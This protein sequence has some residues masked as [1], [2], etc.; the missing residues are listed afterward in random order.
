MTGSKEMFMEQREMEMNEI[1]FSKLP[2]TKANITAQAETAVAHII[3]GQDAFSIAETM[4]AVE[5]F[6][7]IVRKDKRLVE[8]VR[9]ELEKEKGK[10]QTANGTKIECAEVGTKYDYSQ[11]NHPMLTEMTAEVERLNAAIKE[12]QEFLKRVPPA[13]MEVG[14]NDELVKVYPPSKSSTSS[15]KVTLAK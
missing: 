8:Y 10:K 15:Y 1:I 6:I 11:C 3:E 5:E 2:V 13:G 4:S 12:L 9:T 14:I 7:S